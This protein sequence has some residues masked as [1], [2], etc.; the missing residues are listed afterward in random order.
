MQTNT[1]LINQFLNGVTSVANVA[2]NQKLMLDEEQDRLDFYEKQLDVQKRLNDFTRSI[3]EDPDPSNY[4]DK[5]KLLERE[6]TGLKK[7]FRLKKYSEQ[8]GT[9]LDQTLE[10]TRIGAADLQLQRVK[11]I[12]LYRMDER[13]KE[14]IELGGEG[15]LE[16][17]RHDLF[18]NRH[19]F[20]GNQAAFE[21]YADEKI[22][23]FKFQDIFKK[24]Q[25][26]DFASANEY[27]ASSSEEVLEIAP[28]DLDKIKGAVW[29]QERFRRS[30]EDRVWSK[31]ADNLWTIG[32]QAASSGQLNHSWVD[33]NRQALGPSYYPRLKGMLQ[34]MEK[35]GASSGEMS[36]QEA[37]QVSRR[38]YSGILGANTQGDHDRILSDIQGAVE[39]GMPRTE[40]QGLV[41]ALNQKDIAHY[42]QAVHDMVDSNQFLKDRPELKAMF[43]E[44]LGE[45]LGI[46]MPEDM[47]LTALNVPLETQMV[48]AQNIMG[49]MIKT[50][51]SAELAK[52]YWDTKAKQMPAGITTWEEQDNW[53]KSIETRRSLEVRSAN[54][55][56][57][58]RNLA[59]WTDMGMDDDERF[60]DNLTAGRF[61]GMRDADPTFTATL[62]NYV[63]KWTGLVKDLGIDFNPS[64]GDT[65]FYENTTGRPVW[66]VKETI[67]GVP[68]N[69]SQWV[70]YSL[71]FG[72][73]QANNPLGE[74]GTMRT[75][76]PVRWFQ[77]KWIDATSKLGT[78]AYN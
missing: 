52:Q 55:N 21:K 22:Y 30:E 36:A 53:K 51:L 65:I 1:Q 23:Q 39:N 8:F 59:R 6:L 41:S 16:L 44:Q 54:P 28:G 56:L 78:D 14:R 64:K 68:G 74:K 13:I 25:S 43:F 76:V 40:A 10:T 19:L 67:P 75:E 24:A 29:D 35:V 72:E 73:V 70:Y 47:K 2:M 49:A 62:N 5:L 66:R 77:G 61:A 57:N 31:N 12:S 69:A 4:D 34:D 15:N 63:T 37:K 18:E 50:Q 42:D 26:M 48:M 3:Q 38:I 7:G 20:G 46:Q 11:E 60:L 9:T 27:L 58:D 32:V 33:A 17:V 71:K 45:K